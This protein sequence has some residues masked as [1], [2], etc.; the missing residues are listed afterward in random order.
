VTARPAAPTGIASERAPTFAGSVDV[1]DFLQRV[2]IRIYEHPAIYFNSGV[3]S[4]VVRVT[5]VLFGSNE[6]VLDSELPQKTCYQT[7][8]VSLTTG[9]EP[10][11][12]FRLP[13]LH[14]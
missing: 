8:L 14:F 4:E 11:G 3:G 6:L 1:E 13:S 12:H 7:C 2:D 9:E 10:Y 5:L